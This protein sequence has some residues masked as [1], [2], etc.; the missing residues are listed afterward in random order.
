MSTIPDSYN[1]DAQDQSLP[2]HEFHSLLQ[3]WIWTMFYIWWCYVYE[4]KIP[5]ELLHLFFIEG[6]GI[7]KTFMLMFLIQGILRF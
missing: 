4:K 1:V 7:G 6:V 2:T 5:N 3:K